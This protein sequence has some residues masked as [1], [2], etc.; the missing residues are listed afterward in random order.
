[1]TDGMGSGGHNVSVTGQDSVVVQAAAGQMAQLDLHAQWLSKNNNVRV[2]IDGEEDGTLLQGTALPPPEGGGRR[3]RSKPGG[4]VE[5]LLVTDILTSL[6]FVSF[7]V[8][9]ICE[10]GWRMLAWN[11]TALPCRC[12]GA[13][14][15]A[16]VPSPT[17]F[18]YPNRSS[19]QPMAVSA[20]FAPA[21][22]SWVQGK[23]E[24]SAAGN[25]DRFCKYY[26][27]VLMPDGRVLLVP[28]MANHVGLYDPS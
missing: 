25:N 11:E 12:L 9:A 5:V 28:Y 4:K 15:K 8:S 23:D 1:M 22:D 16:T 18:T 3:F 13:S 27:G 2:Y 24:L 19:A 17:D 7:A 26:G 20:G 21:A 6:S 14:C 10:D